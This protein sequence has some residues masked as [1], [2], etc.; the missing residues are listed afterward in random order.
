[1]AS[2]AC[3]SATRQDSGRGAEDLQGH[4]H[5]GVHAECVLGHDE[6]GVE[7]RLLRHRCVG[8]PAQAVPGRSQPPADEQI[9]KL[10]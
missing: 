10:P 6:D 2:L 5:Q 4:E 8:G 7:P 1:M 3:R 9:S